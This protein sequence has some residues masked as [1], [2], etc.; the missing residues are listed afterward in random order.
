MAVGLCNDGNDD[1]DDG[2]NEPLI[3]ELELDLDDLASRVPADLLEPSQPSVEQEHTPSDPTPTPE[4][5][6]QGGER[7]TYKKGN[8][9]SYKISYCGKL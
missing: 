2:G 7:G 9:V 6:T 4:T 1:E 3:R 5:D 8:Y